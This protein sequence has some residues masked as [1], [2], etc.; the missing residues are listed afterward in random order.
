MAAAMARVTTKT[1]YQWIRDEGLPV[2]RSSGNGARRGA[3][4]DA[5]AFFHWYVDRITVPPG[6]LD[7]EQER[8]RLAKWQADSKH[9]DVEQRAGTLLAADDVMRWVA[10]MIGTVRQ[11]FLQIPAA[12]GQNVPAEHSAKVTAE[13]QRLIYEAL[14]ELSVRGAPGGRA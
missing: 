4:L 12:V 10:G 2:V 1:V 9:Q 14:A 13:V 6:A 3:R 11:R 8:A 7:L 5:V